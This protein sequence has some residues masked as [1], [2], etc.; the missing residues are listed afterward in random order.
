MRVLGKVPSLVTIEGRAIW[1][2]QGN[3][4]VFLLAYLTEIYSWHCHHGIHFLVVSM[5]GE[6]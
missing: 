1:G 6:M 2:K 4:Y 5:E 3:E